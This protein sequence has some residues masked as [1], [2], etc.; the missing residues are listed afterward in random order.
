MLGC[1][2][3]FVVERQIWW[4]FEQ[5]SVKFVGVVGKK[6]FYYGVCCVVVRENCLLCF[7]VVV[8]Y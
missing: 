4:I 2:V 5:I 6:F 1:Q 3:F 7:F 8:G